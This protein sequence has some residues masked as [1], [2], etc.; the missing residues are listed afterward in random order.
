MSQPE[1][2]DKHRFLD[3]Q[4]DRLLKLLNDRLFQPLDRLTILLRLILVVALSVWF[5]FTAVNLWR[6]LSFNVIHRPVYHVAFAVGDVEGESALL[7]EAI[8]Q[9]VEATYPNIRLNLMETVG[10]VDNVER[11]AAGKAQLI[12]VQADVDPGPNARSVAVLYRDVFQLVVQNQT[13]IQQFTDLKGRRI[14]VPRESG[15]FL[16]F[17]E[18]AHHFDLMAEDFIFIG[19]DD[20]DAEAAFQNNRV[21]AVF[22]VR[23]AGNWVIQRL[24]RQHKG[25]LLPI[26]QAQAMKIQHPM[27]KAATIPRGTYQGTAPVVPPADTSTV[28]VYKMLYAS[29][30][31]DKRVV[32]A[33]ATVLQNHRQAIVNAIPNK[34]VEIKPLVPDIKPP[35]STFGIPIHPGALVAYSKNQPSFIAK[36]FDFLALILSITVPIASWIWELRSRAE[37]RGKSL[38]EGY[39]SDVVKLM[40][41]EKSPP[42]QT[43]EDQ[44]KELYAIFDR[45]AKRLVNE[46]IS[47]EAFRTFNEAYKTA[48]EKI[49]RDI[50]TKA[51]YQQS[52]QQQKTA[53][54]IRDLVLVNQPQAFSYEDKLNQMNQVLQ[55]V[56]DDLASNRISQESFRTFI[57]VYNTTK[58]FLQRGA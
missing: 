52:L 46:D 53:Q 37:K 8:K 7:G 22:R 49:E 20:E 50:E 51:Q 34:A 54:Y 24:V 47:Q 1:A 55:Q 18:I 25:R 27:F 17:L 23:A 2:S 13:D 58:E 48:C 31:T 21:D 36:N 3:R 57:E 40:D 41:D 12:T 4:Q 56:L 15:Q 42:H 45:A 19:V 29:K 35:S 5:G 26:E 32:R 11:L 14:G 39:I 16:S 28:A 30:R 43:L 33:I 9:V 6:S 44:Q 10:S 38:V